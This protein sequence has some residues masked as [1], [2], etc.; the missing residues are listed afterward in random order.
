MSGQ[1]VT[2]VV[3]MSCEEKGERAQ[4]VC[5]YTPQKRLSQ[6]TCPL[7]IAVRIAE[8]QTRVTASGGFRLCW[9]GTSL[10]LKV[11]DKA[12]YGNRSLG[13]AQMFPIA[14]LLASRTRRIGFP[15]R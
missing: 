12:T 15:R 5:L 8:L 1:L 2:G 9:Q 4:E 10:L 11:E 7:V 13:C 6:L 14:D 3:R